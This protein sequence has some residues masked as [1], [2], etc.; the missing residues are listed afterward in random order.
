MRLR[1]WG[2]SRIDGLRVD[3]CLDVA[4]PKSEVSRRAKLISILVV[5]ARMSMD[6]C[7]DVEC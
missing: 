5:S 1:F 4:F 7:E 3:I 6:D 2:K